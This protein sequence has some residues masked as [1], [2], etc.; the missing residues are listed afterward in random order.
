KASTAGTVQHRDINAVQ[1]T[2]AE[3]NK[4]MVALK[5]NGELAVLDPKGRELEKFKVPYGASV[6]VADGEKVK[7]R[8]QLIVWDP[9]I[10]PILAEKG[11]TVRYEDIEEGETARIEEEKKGQGGKLVVIEHK[12]E[13]HPRIT[14]EGSDGKILDFHYL[15]AKAR[16]E[17]TNGQKIEAGPMLAR[18]PRETA[19]T[20]DI[21]GGLPR[22][23]EI[24]EARKPKDLAVLAE[25]SGNIEL[26]SDK[27][28]GKMTIV[29]R[30]EAG[31]EREHHV[32]QDKELQ[33]H[34]GDF[35]EAG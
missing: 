33:V 27:R 12:G 31:M 23:T 4:H 3:G 26:R 5:R 24:F 13:R 19:G 10:T 8:Q 11:G 22:V 30:S 9:H 32:P 25:I 34:T 6:M 15:P 35:V 16:I 2:D 20:Q 7:P 21:T 29:V 17:V 28:R 18:Q 1:I 14:I